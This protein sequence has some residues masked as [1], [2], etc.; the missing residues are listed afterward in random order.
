M[1]VCRGAQTLPQLIDA[2]R[3]SRGPT[4]A[5]CDLIGGL[6]MNQRQG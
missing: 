3:P 4:L 5:L 1:W 2:A 6:T